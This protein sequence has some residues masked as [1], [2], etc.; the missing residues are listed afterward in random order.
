[1]RGQFNLFIIRLVLPPYQRLHGGPKLNS[2]DQK[3]RI[4]VIFCT[5]IQEY[6]VFLLVFVKFTKYF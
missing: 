1:M 2:K 5:S 4:F 6:S 3:F